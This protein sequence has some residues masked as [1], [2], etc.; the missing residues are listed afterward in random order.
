MGTQLEKLGA[1]SPGRGQTK[2]DGPGRVRGGL[3]WAF[4]CSRGWRRGAGAGQGLG[5]KKQRCGPGGSGSECGMSG[6][7]SGPP[8]GQQS[9]HVLVSYRVL[10][11]EDLCGWLLFLMPVLAGHPAG[12][13]RSQVG[14]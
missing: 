9:S 1:V 13:G 12:M 10:S 5:G 8:G 4:F 2:T 6:S 3:P 7:A 11:L 14:W